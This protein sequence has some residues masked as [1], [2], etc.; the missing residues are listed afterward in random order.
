[1][2]FLVGF[3]KL[4]EASEAIAI[5]ERYYG[6]QPIHVKTR[7]FVEEVFQEIAEEAS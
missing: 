1:V 4:T 2:K 6:N 5:V 3:L 7:F